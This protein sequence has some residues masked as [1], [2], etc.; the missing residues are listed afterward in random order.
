MSF[1]DGILGDCG[2]PLVTGVWEHDSRPCIRGFLLRGTKWTRRNFCVLFF[3][4]WCMCANELVLIDRALKWKSIGCWLTITLSYWN[5]QFLYL[6]LIF[7]NLMYCS[8]FLCKELNCTSWLRATL[9]EIIFIWFYYLDL[10]DDPYSSLKS[11]AYDW[12]LDLREGLVGKCFQF[13]MILSNWVNWYVFFL[14]L[15]KEVPSSRNEC[16]S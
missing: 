6:P 2:S 11:F 15:T 12:K 8:K 5:P 9:I 16:G 3:T 7:W 14:I 10:T 13:L 1:F 4:E